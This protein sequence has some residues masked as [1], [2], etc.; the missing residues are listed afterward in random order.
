MLKWQEAVQSCRRNR[1]VC[2]ADALHKLCASTRPH[3]CHAFSCRPTPR[4]ATCHRGSYLWDP[5]TQVDNTVRRVYQEHG[6]VG[7]DL[8]FVIG[9]GLD[10]RE[11]DSQLACK[12]G[13][14]VDHLVPARPGAVARPLCL[15]C[16]ADSWCES[17][18]SACL[19]KLDNN[20]PLC[21]NH[22]AV[23]ACLPVQRRFMSR[24]A[25]PA[26]KGGPL[27]PCVHA[28][29]CSP[30]TELCLASVSFCTKFMHLVAAIHQAA[31]AA[32]VC[33][34]SRKQD[35]MPGLRAAAKE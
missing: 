16:K 15:A 35:I 11:G 10:G 9:Q 22:R 13:G 26:G 7:N 28:D 33:E 2:E 24:C 25:L 4:C 5:N 1:V 21:S 27:S 6:S 17:L 18:C 12:E 30:H 8:A 20:D 32:G 29:A 23:E 34:G 14:F 19:A 3:T 31:A